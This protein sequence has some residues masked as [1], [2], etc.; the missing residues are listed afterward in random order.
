MNIRIC[1]FFFFTSRRL[2]TRLVSDWSSDVCSSDLGQ[3]SIFHW[4]MVPKQRSKNGS[5]MLPRP[6]SQPPVRV[7]RLACD[8]RSEERR[9]GKGGRMRMEA[10][11]VGGIVEAD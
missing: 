9:V 5:R 4:V 2:H 10:E 7:T 3:R 11:S 6:A 8:A 1:V